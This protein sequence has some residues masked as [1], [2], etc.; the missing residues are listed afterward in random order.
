MY[1]FQG[2]CCKLN[3]KKIAEYPEL[4]RTHEHFT[5]V[6]RYIPPHPAS[7]VGTLGLTC[8]NG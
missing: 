6:H 4:V 8:D 1:D 7:V 2:L 3:V 5:V